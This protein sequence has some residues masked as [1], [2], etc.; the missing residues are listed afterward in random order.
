MSNVTNIKNKM[1]L[2]SQNNNKYDGKYINAIE[3]SIQNDFVATVVKPVF[4]LSIVACKINS[5]CKHRAYQTQ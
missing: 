2:C 3:L 1:Y 4:F 5:L